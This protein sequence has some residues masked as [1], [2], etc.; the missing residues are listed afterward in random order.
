MTIHAILHYTDPRLRNKALPVTD[1][2]D[3]IR[4]LI[5][6]MFETMYD[7]NGAGLAAPQINVAKRVI[8]MDLS[9]D[10]SQPLCFINPEITAQ[11]GCQN[12]E[13]GCLS[14]PNFYA[15]VKRAANVTVN[16]LDKNG[17][18]FELNAEGYLAICIQHEIDHLDGKLY[19]D[20]LSPLRRR[21]MEKKLDKLRRQTF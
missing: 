4:T 15:T 7:D 21:M 19:I 3:E 12:L 16:A 20:Y 6:D 8:V 1:I 17:K 18:P 11:E 10:R 5:A 13:E 9:E 2:N 14:V